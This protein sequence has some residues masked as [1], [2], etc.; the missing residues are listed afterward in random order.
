MAEQKERKPIKRGR[1]TLLDI[2][3]AIF[4]VAAIGALTLAAFMGAKWVRDTYLADI[5]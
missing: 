3:T 4:G 5:F 2:L 1:W